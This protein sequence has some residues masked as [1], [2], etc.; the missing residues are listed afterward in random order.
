[1][2]S[3]PTPAPESPH[4]GAVLT[5]AGVARGMRDLLP[6]AVSITIF[7]VA[8]GIAS[9]TAGIHPGIAVLM[10]AWVFAG[11]AQFAAL[12]MWQSPVPW[13]PLALA[14]FAVNARHMPLGASL[15]SWCAQLPPFKRY[16]AMVLLSDLNWAASTVAMER[17]ERDVGHL[18]GG[19]VT[20]WLSWTIGT[21]LGVAIPGI[22]LHDVQR[23]GLDLIFVAFFACT[24]IGLRR[25]RIDDLPWLV[26]GVVALGA[27]WLLPANWHVLVGGLA[28]GI[29][30]MLQKS[31]PRE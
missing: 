8:F 17:G 2:I 5:M 19:G 11:A 27:V 6:V 1:M 18:I 31:A 14:T 9:H 16:G 29:A 26:A 25:G 10:S 22:T 24:I 23:F 21:G 30:G 4:G 7:G 15:Y 3:S 12:D 13:I 28:G 20:L